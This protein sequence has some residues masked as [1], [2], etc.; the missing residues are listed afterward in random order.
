MANGRGGR[1][2][3]GDSPQASYS[4]AD[5]CKRWKVGA[6]KVYTFL[7]RGDLVGVNVAANLAGKPQWRIT[8]E[9]VQQFERGRSSLPAPNLQRRRRKPQN[10][11]DYYPD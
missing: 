7:R 11:V 9:S 8:A 10:L 2:V 5:L 6:D 4:V 1:R 3:K